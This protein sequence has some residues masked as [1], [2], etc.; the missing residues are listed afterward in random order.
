MSAIIQRVKSAFSSEERLKQQARK[1]L[2]IADKIIVAAHTQHLNIKKCA[3]LQ[4]NL[5]DKLDSVMD[6]AK[7][8]GNKPL[9]MQAAKLSEVVALW[10]G[11]TKNMLEDQSLMIQFMAMQRTFYLALLEYKGVVKDFVKTTKQFTALKRL[12]LNI[13]KQIEDASSEAAIAF[14]EL[15]KSLA[16]INV[17][18]TRLTDYVLLDEFDEERLSKRFDEERRKL[19]QQS[20]KN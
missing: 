10:H 7:K 5:L 12:G 6:G 8:I 13:P 18:Y 16:S 3:D 4:K 20:N 1:A 19:E 9:W 2:D 11:V 17:K 15:T 14:A